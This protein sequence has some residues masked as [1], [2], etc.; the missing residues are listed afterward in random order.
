MATAHRISSH[1]NQISSHPSNSVAL[2]NNKTVYKI[3]LRAARE[4][5][6]SYA[7]KT[8]DSKSKI[9]LGSRPLSLNSLDPEQ[10]HSASCTGIASRDENLAPWRRV[11]VILVK[12]EQSQWHF[13]HSAHEAGKLISLS[14]TPS[15]PS[16]SA[17]QPTNCCRITFRTAV[18]TAF[19]SASTFQS[20]CRHPLEEEMTNATCQTLFDL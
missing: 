17:N 18:T 5:K 19:S 1:H 10:V 16:S 15:S 3:H 13:R 7:F 12:E 20:A 2:I 8:L 11:K 6:V 14:E 4:S 9:C